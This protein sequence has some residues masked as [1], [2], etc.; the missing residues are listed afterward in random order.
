MSRVE[1]SL[2]AE[3]DIDGIA[4]R[5]ALDKPSAAKRWVFRLNER[6]EILAE[7]PGSGPERPEL[8]P[9]L[10][11]LP[12]GNYLIFYRPTGEGVEIVRVVDGHQ[13]LNRLF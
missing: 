3:I 11:S 13:D 7:W 8:Q 9:G 1:L 2:K 5:I 6:M 4:Y 10:R 12:F